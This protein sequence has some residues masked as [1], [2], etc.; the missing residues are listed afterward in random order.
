MT[1]KQ[2]DTRGRKANAPAEVIDVQVNGAALARDGDAAAVVAKH[3]REAAARFL[4]GRSYERAAFVEEAR[5]FVG[6]GDMA[7]FQAGLRLIC[8]KESEPHGDFLEILENQ[9]GMHPRTA[10]RLMQTAARLSKPA[11]APHAEKLLRLGQSKVAELLVEDDETLVAFAEGGTVAGMTL[12]K[13]DAMSLREAR[14]NL[15]EQEATLK[16]KDKVIEGKSKK[17]DA[18]EEQ[19]H[20]RASSDA[21]EREKAQIELL[22]DDSRQAVEKLVRALATVDEVMGAPATG[23]AG[24]AA[25]QTVDYLVQYFVDACFERGISIDL[26]ERVSPIYVQQPKT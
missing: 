15:R 19:L 24:L 6:H 11:L 1:E 13:Y 21:A 10:Q 22:R 2:K 5:F 23:S 8:I 17:I 20:R 16:A 18:L 4:D 3:V 14:R 25:R 9:I 12:D 26:A 7:Y